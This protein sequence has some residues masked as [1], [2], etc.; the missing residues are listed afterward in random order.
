MTELEARLDLDIPNSTAPDG[1]YRLLAC[2]A[3]ALTDEAGNELDGDGDFNGGD[4]FARTFRIDLIDDFVNGHFDCGL[5]PWIAV[6]SGGS[7]IVHDPL[8]DVDNAVISGSAHATNEPGSTDL[9]LGQCVNVAGGSVYDFSGFVLL[10]TPGV[11]IDVIRTC[12]FFEAADCVGATLPAQAFI[13]TIA[14]D[15]VW[16]PFSGGVVVPAPVHSALCQATLHNAAGVAYEAFLDDLSLDL[17]ESPVIFE[18]GFESGDTL[19]LVERGALRLGE[20][21]H[22]EEDDERCV[23]RRAGRWLRAPRGD[24]AV[25]ALSVS[26]A[27]TPCLNV[28]IVPA[29]GAA[30]L[31]CL[32]PGSRLRGLERQADWT[33]VE[34]TGGPAGW[35]ATRYLVPVSQAASPGAIARS[36]RPPFSSRRRSTASRDSW[37]S[38]STTRPTR[39]RAPAS[40]ASGSRPRTPPSIAARPTTSA[41]RPGTSNGTSG[42]SRCSAATSKVPGSCRCSTWSSSRTPAASPEAAASCS[43]PGLVAGVDFVDDGAGNLDVT[44]PATCSLPAGDYWLS[45]LADMDLATG[46]QWLWAERS[47]QNGAVFAWENPLDGFSTGCTAWTPANGC[48]ASAPDLLF[49]LV[50]TTVPVELQSISID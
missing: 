50:G 37:A 38:R 27:A 49:A 17:L 28:R 8:V 20:D 41:C 34:A 21:E 35:A 36:S 19:G 12:A 5:D 26:A 6:T 30:T 16:L 2:A 32:P 15:G 25:E 1:P 4:D 7:T 48:G 22:V 9:A 13:D 47:A 18:D 14:T 43:Y 11:S 44:L 29:A 10:D 33:R 3:G 23:G 31:G 46:G 24:A 39:P 40:S 42:A 45:V